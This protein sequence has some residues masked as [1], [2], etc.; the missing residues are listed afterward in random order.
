M[1]RQLLVFTIYLLCISCSNTLYVPGYKQNSQIIADGKLDDW[2]LP[3]KFGSEDGK[4]QYSITFDEK[5]IFVAIASSDQ[6][7]QMGIL[8]NGIDFYFDINGKKNKTIHLHY[9]ENKGAEFTIEGF[10]K[11]ENGT[12]SITDPTTLKAG[13]YADEKQG[14]GIELIIPKNLL[15]QNGI[16]KKNHINIGIALGE[17]KMRGNANAKGNGEQ[18][19]AYKRSGNMGNEFNNVG[20]GMRGGGMRGG[21]RGGGMR[22]EMRGGNNYESRGNGTK[23]SI[24]WNSFTID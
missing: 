13:S 2:S 11:L 8:R 12:Y 1:Q 6:F 18:R 20:G 5:N 24:N 17:I 19:N 7:S 10:Q 14:L 15:V 16:F 9:P 22:G 21:M 23:S 4:Y 3:L